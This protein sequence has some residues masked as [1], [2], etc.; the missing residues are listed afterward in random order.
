MPG[1]AQDDGELELVVE[2]LGQVLRDR[3]IGSSGPTIAST[4]WKKLIHG[5]IWC[6]QSTFFD[7]SSCSRK[8]PAVWKNF[9]GTIGASSFA[10]ASGV[11]SS[12]SSRA[13]ALEVVAHRRHVEPHDLVAVD[14]AD[15]PAVVRDELHEQILCATS[16]YVCAVLTRPSIARFS[17]SSTS[18]RPVDVP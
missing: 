3:S 6:D 16:A 7:S 12:V 9:F 4:F 11:R 1:L 14:T 5:A 17:P 2:L 8:L 10:S 18:I 15:L 13:A